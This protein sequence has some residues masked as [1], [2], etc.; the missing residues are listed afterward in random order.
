MN[1][2]TVAVSVIFA[3]LSLNSYAASWNYEGDTGP[4]HWDKMDPAYATCGTDREQSPVNIETHHAKSS[5]LPGLSF[6]YAIKT[7]EMTN[8]GHT[9][10]IHVPPGNQLR[11]DN[12][13]F[14]LRQFHFH[15]PSEEE[16]DGKSFPMDA[17]FVHNA[18]DGQIVVVAVLFKEGRKNQG[19][20]SIFNTLPNV[21]KTTTIAALNLTSVLPT[22]GSYYKYQGSLT[23]PPCSTGVTWL[24][25][26]TPIELS[27]D[28][29]AAFQKLYR[30]NAR[31]VQPLNSR[32]IESSD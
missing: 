29:I 24:V 16:M 9:I 22:Q 1:I 27:H 6:Q 19:M 7:A 30:M 12:E 11:F 31:P 10:Q 8:N 21:G 13:E 4:T 5:K 25:M 28:Q 26:K 14:E 23:T 20:E 2:S 17:H 3:T 15:T 32:V 18:E